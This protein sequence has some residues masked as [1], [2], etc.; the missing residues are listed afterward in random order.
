MRDSV[1]AEILKEMETARS[2]TLPAEDQLWDLQVK[3]AGEFTVMCKA[4]AP[5]RWV[6]EGQFQFTN[7]GDMNL[8]NSHVRK[9]QALNAEYD[10]IAA[11]TDHQAQLVVDG[12]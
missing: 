11:D 9:L 12:Y 10:R 4:F 6:N 7:A 2:I 1:R 5:R 3:M 8:Y